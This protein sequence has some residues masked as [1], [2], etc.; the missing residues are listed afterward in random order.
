MPSYVDT[1]QFIADHLPEVVSADET[2]AIARVILAASLYADRACGRPVGYFSAASGTASTRYFR[3]DGS[4]ILRIPQ[5]VIGSATVENVPVSAYYENT[6]NGWLYKYT[7]EDLA[8]SGEVY[9][10]G[11]SDQYP[12][13]TPGKRYAVA[14]RWGFAAIP[15]DLQQAVSMIVLRWWNTIHGT[16]GQVSPAGFVIERAVDPA[17]AEIL[18]QY[19]R[20]EFEI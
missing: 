8:A 9:I 2:A 18:A 16:L 10:S 20:G 6:E 5:H 17:A 15:Q 11:T 14:A 4:K 12:V 1:T 7:Q 19:T 13:W 3:G